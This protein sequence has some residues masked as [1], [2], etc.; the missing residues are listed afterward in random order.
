MNND[1]STGKIFALHQRLIDATFP[2][3]QTD[4]STILMI[5][6]YR[7]PWVLVVPKRLGVEEIFDLSKDDRTT[8]IEEISQ[9]SE[10]MSFFFKPFRINIADIG[11]RVEQLHIHIVA[12]QLD[13]P[14][15][16]KVVWSR[17]RLEYENMEELKKM[18][19]ALMEICSTLK[20][21][22]PE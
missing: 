7:Y 13:D 3:G 2:L 5:N 19:N 16:P 21:F 9:I 1:I 6:D 14:A 20:S 12:R 22:Q 15:W 10:Q 11:N 17:E 18:K 8:L 4:L